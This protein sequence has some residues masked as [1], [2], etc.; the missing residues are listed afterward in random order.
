MRPVKSDAVEA[1]FKKHYNE[2]LLYTLSL[3]KDKSTAEEIVSEAFF[4]ALETADDEIRNFKSWL[5]T[6][7]RNLFYNEQRRHRH[8]EELP[9]ELSGERDALI[10]EI[11]RREDY[12][13]LYRAI[14]LLP[15]LQAEVITL[16]YFE[17]L[18]VNEISQITEKTADHVKVILFRARE[19][20]R[21]KLEV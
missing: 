9:E 3:C 17:G 20:L 18:S 8:H 13:A 5:L 15:Q 7:C 19:A 10:N 14:G 1:L 21:K 12:R 16:F 11:V 4:R 6:V 2:A